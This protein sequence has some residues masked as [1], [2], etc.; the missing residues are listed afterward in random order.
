MVRGAAKNFK[1]VTVISSIH[2]YKDLVL[3]LSKN[4]GF[5]TLDFR[6]RM[7]EFAFS[8]TAFYDA[9]ISNYFN[10]LSKNKFPNKKIIFGKN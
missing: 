8:E 7:A 10:N 9:I 4:A 1:N 6:K 5:T 2:N 3:E